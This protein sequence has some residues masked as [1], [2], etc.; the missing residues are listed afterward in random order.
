M[1]LTHTPFVP[2]GHKHVWLHRFAV[3][4]AAATVALIATGALVT[5]TGS[6]DAIPDWPTAYGTLVPPVLTSGVMIEWLHRVVAGVIGVLVMG[7]AVWVA[8]SPF[9]RGVKALGLIAAAAVVAQ[10]VL[11][12]IRV[13]V[14]TSEPLQATLLPLTGAADSLALAISFAIAHGVLAQVVLGLVFALVLFTQPLTAPSPPLAHRR[15]L[16]LLAL[17]V[18]VLL[19]GQLLL[20]ALIRHLHMALVIPDFPTSFGRLIPPFGNLPFDPDNPLWLSREEFAF[21]VAINFAHRANGLLI[22]LTILALFGLVRRLPD[23]RK[24]PPLRSLTAWQLGL[25]LG[26]IL[27]GG[28]VVWTKLS[29]PITIAHVAVGATLL[30]LSVL[31]LLHCAGAAPVAIPSRTEVAA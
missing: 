16:F 24:H 12:G 19:V 11:G 13:L 17:A 27:L 20:G 25:V 4:V 6:G 21:G 7:L 29:I 10:A 28:L 3:L 31:V 5:S 23:A 30:G 14:V 8:V 9:P 2:I 18:V 26:Q 15:P 22:A 1:N